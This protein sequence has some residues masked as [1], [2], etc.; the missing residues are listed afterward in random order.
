MCA[1][2]TEGP[3]CGITLKAI[4]PELGSWVTKLMFWAKSFSAY[5]ALTSYVWL[6]WVLAASGKI[7]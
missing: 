2:N 3:E 4:Q 1:G 7:V 5:P 6:G